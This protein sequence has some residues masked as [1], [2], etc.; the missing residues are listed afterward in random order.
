M[1]A[2]ESQKPVKRKLVD[3][4]ELSGGSPVGMKEIETVSE[5]DMTR[6]LEIL[7]G[8][9]DVRDE[10]VNRAIGRMEAGSHGQEALDGTVEGLMNELGL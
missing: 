1:K 5:K 2:A 3:Q 9:P 4:V 7:N 8:L 6:Y 10:D